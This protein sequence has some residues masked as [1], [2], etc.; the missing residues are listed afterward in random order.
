MFFGE[1]IQRKL[2]KKKMLSQLCVVVSMILSEGAYQKSNKTIPWSSIG[3]DE[4]SRLDG[5]E[6]STLTETDIKT[7]NNDILRTMIA[8]NMAKLT[9]ACRGFTVRQIQLLPWKAF[10]NLSPQCLESI[11]GNVFTE[12]SIPQLQSLP[13]QITK[14]I[15]ASQISSLSSYTCKRLPIDSFIK[16][17]EQGCQGFTKNCLQQMPRSSF[18]IMSSECVKQIQPNS[19]IAISPAMLSIEFIAKLMPQQVSMFTSNQC[20]GLSPSQVYSLNPESCSGLTSECIKYLQPI[21][22][23]SLTAKCGSRISINLLPMMS[24]EQFMRLPTLSHVVGEVGISSYSSIALRIS[25][26]GSMYCS[27]ITQSDA[28]ELSPYLCKRLTSTCVSLLSSNVVSDMSPECLLAINFGAI[29]PEVVPFVS[30]ELFEIISARKLEFLSSQQCEGI[31]A[32]QAAAI[33]VAVCC[34]PKSASCLRLI[35]EEATSKLPNDCLSCLLPKN[36]IK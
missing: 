1:Q 4:A 18:S 9:S 25:S 17:L 12:I 16:H 34:S 27:V 13:S 28:K 10:S 33:S 32:L 29:Q 30:N 15:K 6:W 23:T 20:K 26:I 35:S 22:F 7:L 36:E 8:D 24:R 21:V 2:L 3:V 31:T 5:G 19:L 14:F 11:E